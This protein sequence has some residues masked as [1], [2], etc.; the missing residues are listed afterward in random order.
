MDDR[1]YAQDFRARTILEIEPSPR[2]GVAQRQS[3]D[4]V[5]NNDA[6]E[7]DPKSLRAI[8]RKIQMPRRELYRP[9]DQRHARYDG[10]MREVTVEIREIG[11]NKEIEFRTIS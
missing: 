1:A 10:H 8:D 2:P 4:R 9:V 5:G 3:H 7:F 6:A 11:R